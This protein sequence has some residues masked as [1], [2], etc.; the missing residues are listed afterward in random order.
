[1]DRLRFWI[2]FDELAADLGHRAANTDSTSAQVDILNIEA[3]ELTKSKPGVS[4]EQDN[5][6]LAAAYLSKGCYLAC[7]Q[8]DVR[9]VAHRRKLGARRRVPAQELVFLDGP[10]KG[11]LEDQMRPPNSPRPEARRRHGIHPLL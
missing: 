2:T 1:M 3:S 8:V 5:I 10:V 6:A 4:Q 9:G 7:A 11:H